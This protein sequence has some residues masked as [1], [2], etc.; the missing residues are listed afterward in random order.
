MNSTVRSGMIATESYYA[1]ITNAN[2]LMTK[3]TNA[4]NDTTATES[5]MKPFILG[6]A[7]DKMQLG[8]GNQFFNVRIIGMTTESQ[9]LKNIVTEIGGGRSKAGKN[10]KRAQAFYS[11]GNVLVTPTAP[12]TPF[13]GN[14]A[15]YLDGELA[16]G[17]AQMRIHG[18]ATFMNHFSYNITDGD[19]VIFVKDANDSGDVYFGESFQST[20][21][22]FRFSTK[23][24]FD[25]SAVFNGL[26]SGS[27][28]NMF[29]E[30]VGFNS[31]F[32]MGDGRTADFSND[33]Y[34]NGGI[35]FQS[36]YNPEPQP[37]STNFSGTG[38]LHYTNNLNLVSACA[39]GTCG[40]T[41]TGT[42]LHQ[43][44][45]YSTPGYNKVGMNLAT[46]SDNPMN[47]PSLMGINPVRNEPTLD[48]RQITEPPSSKQFLSFRN[49]LGGS[50]VYMSTLE[51]W[52]NDYPKDK[53][54]QYYFNDHLLV[55]VDAS[56]NGNFNGNTFNNK[57]VFVVG[58]GD[59]HPDSSVDFTGNLYRGGSTMI[60]ADRDAKLSL[61]LGNNDEFNGLIYIDSTN[62]KNHTFGSA[63][64]NPQ[65]SCKF[66]GAIISKG[67]DATWSLNPG[68]A[69]DVKR[70]Q[71]LLN[72]FTGFVKGNT[73][74]DGLVASL[75]DSTKGVTFTPI[76][77]Y[78]Y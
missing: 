33:V 72:S 11:V 36:Q 30:K 68:G 64:N 65:H 31:S 60:F 25:K 45:V 6:N 76:G 13:Y 17:N 19:S 32:S 8:D 67:K 62:D 69:I 50:D 34:M 54:P 22:K 26:T 56:F 75:E 49:D 77:Y 48:W 58:K 61:K 55:N 9:K 7:G 44:N 46:K 12:Q 42:S 14:N 29:R 71:N 63:T 3:I 5:V 38:T 47:I 52:Y 66:S 59:N 74:S 16:A 70:D 51:Q 40:H 1:N 57:I 24:Y 37:S 2:G 27:S 20:S 53:F 21:P 15:M 28:Y 4:L 23:A 39:N 73:G 43:T 18:Y 35:S 78:F 41:G 10:L